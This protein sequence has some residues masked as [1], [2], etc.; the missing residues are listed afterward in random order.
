MTTPHGTQSTPYGRRLMPAVLD[1]E[2]SLNPTRIFAS[3]P[4]TAN[5]NDG[6]RDVYFA[7]VANATNLV[8]QWFQHFFGSPKRDFE[9][10]T[11]IG[12]LDLRYA[13][14]QYAAMKCG[15]KTFSPSPWNP[16][17]TNLSLMDQTESTKLI[18]SKELCPLIDG[19]QMKRQGLRLVPIDSLENL[20]A[21]CTEPFPYNKIFEEAVDDPVVVLHSSGSTCMPRPVTMTHGTFAAVDYD[22][23]I[24]SIPGRKNRDSTIWTFDSN[25]SRKIYETSPPF[26]FSG[27]YN[28]IMVPLFTDA[29]PVYGP[30]LKAPSTRIIDIMECQD[31]GGMLLPPS[32]IEQ[33]LHE[34]N[35]LEYIQ[36]LGILCYAGGPLSQAAGDKIVQYTTLCQFYGSTEVGQV[37]QLVPLPEDWSYMQFHPQAHVRFEPSEDDTFE[38]VLLADEST[39]P[40]MSLPH[41]FLGIKEWRTK[42]L[43]KRHPTKPD[44]WKFYGKIDDIIVLST[45]YKFNPVPMELALQGHPMIAGAVVAGMGRRQTA[46]LVELKSEHLNNECLEEKIWQSVERANAD[47]LNMGG[48]RGI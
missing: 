43:F 8:A 27:F 7:E 17:A 30:P 33:L 9:T 18:F 20:L 45:G 38:L 26:H 46:L 25:C 19:T 5:L 13:I 21:A 23:N 1:A 14:V 11:Y 15:Y 31:I 34:P 37:R 16:V 22:R 48:L 12:V 6:F 24:P 41:N 47:A 3:I 36:R 40:Y 42:D 4:K 29:I 44:L 2:A 28:K 35:G 32:L 10:I 39:R